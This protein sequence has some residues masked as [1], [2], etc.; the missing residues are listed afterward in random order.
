MP[1]PQLRSRPEEHKYPTI[2]SRRLNE[3][4]SNYLTPRATFY[5]SCGRSLKGGCPFMP[6]SNRFLPARRIALET[7]T[8]NLV[9]K[10][11]RGCSLVH[12]GNVE[13]PKTSL[14]PSELRGV[15][16][17][18]MT[19]EFRPGSIRGVGEVV[20]WPLTVIVPARS[21]LGDFLPKERPAAIAVS[22]PA[23][24]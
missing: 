1:S 15:G 19:N 2:S 7:P 3:A 9:R 23:H 21:R 24:S 11:G 5:E 10:F 8:Q 4:T 13:G 12:I 22:E 16:D 20:R 6:E 18:L 17:F 14:N